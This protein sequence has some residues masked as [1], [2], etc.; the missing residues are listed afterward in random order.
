MFSRMPSSDFHYTR[1][2]WTCCTQLG[3]MCAYEEGAIFMID[4]FQ[5]SQKKKEKPRHPSSAADGKKPN[6]QTQKYLSFNR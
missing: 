1:L 3:F 4:D 6:K 5:D 2:T